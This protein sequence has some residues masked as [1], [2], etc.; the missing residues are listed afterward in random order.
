MPLQTGTG[1]SYTPPIIENIARLLAA[2]LIQMQDY[3]VTK[4]G[5]SKDGSEKMKEARA[6]LA[7][8][9]LRDTMLLDSNDQILGM[10]QLVT[11]WPNE[12]TATIGTDGVTPEPSVFTMSKVF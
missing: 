4:P 10:S 11:G 2:G 12:T 6:M 8:I 1:V 9:Q 7:E 5:G 3:G